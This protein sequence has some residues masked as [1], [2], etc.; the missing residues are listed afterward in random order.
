M[1]NFCEFF[2]INGLAVRKC[3]TLG[4]NIRKKLLLVMSELNFA[5][6]TPV[7]EHSLISNC[8]SSQVQPKI[9]LLVF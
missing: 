9:L 3:A 4:V 7:M 5:F 1:A 6:Q 8:Y 2:C